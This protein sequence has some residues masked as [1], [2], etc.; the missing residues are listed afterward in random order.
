[1]VLKG[2]QSRLRFY[3]TVGL[4]STAGIAIHKAVEFVGETCEEPTL[5]EFCEKAVQRMDAGATL[6]FIVKQFPNCFPVSAYRAMRAGEM[7]GTLP[8]ALLALARMEERRL[9]A[10]GRLRSALIYPG[11]V[12]MVSLVLVVAPAVVFGDIASVLAD[13]GVQL[14]VYTRAVLR[15]SELSGSPWVWL[16]FLALAIFFYQELTEERA[17]ARFQRW[18]RLAWSRIPGFSHLITIWSNLHF[19][20]SMALLTEVGIPLT[21]AVSVSLAVTNDPV[22]EKARDAVLTDLGNG[23]SLADSVKGSGLILPFVAAFIESGEEVGKLPESLRKAGSYLDTL[24]ETKTQA[25]LDL[26]QPVL[27]LATGAIVGAIAIGTLKPLSEL[28]VM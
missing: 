12:V 20:Q 14:P 15:L 19:C 11:A 3:T 5:S 27:L 17:N 10:Q 28:L 26:I 18:V 16:F 1:M 24:F 2:A 7:S 6:A 21:E 13:M 23:M 25:L 9:M 4:M 22:M 8:E